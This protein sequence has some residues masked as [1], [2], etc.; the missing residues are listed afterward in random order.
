MPVLVQHRQSACPVRDDR[1]SDTREGAMSEDGGGFTVFTG[2]LIRLLAEGVPNA[3]QEFLDLDTIFNELHKSLRA[4]SR[5]LP[6]KR[7]RNSL[8]RLSLARNPAWKSIEKDASTD[9][10]LDV[11]IIYSNKHVAI[12]R[13]AVRDPAASDEDAS[14]A[15]PDSGKRESRIDSKPDLPRWPPVAEPGAKSFTLYS[16][17]TPVVE[18]SV[19]P[20]GESTES[21]RL[22]PPLDNQSA[23]HA[24]A[25]NAM[26]RSSTP[27]HRGDMSAT[28]QVI[29]DAVKVRRRLAWIVLTQNAQFS[30]VD[31]EVL[32]LAFRNE[33]AIKTYFSARIDKILDQVIIED[34]KLSWVV[35]ASALKGAGAN[36][37]AQVPRPEQGR[38]PGEWPLFRNDEGGVKKFG[39][40]A[41]EAG[42]RDPSVWPAVR[43][44]PPPENSRRVHELWPTVLE[45][46]RRRRRF[47][48]LLLSY[49]SLAGVEE[50]TIRLE[51][52]S[53]HARDAYLAIG[54]SRLIKEVAAEILRFNCEIDPVIAER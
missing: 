20:K 33:S 11:P 9:V 42:V 28:W 49:A 27:F 5:P 37:L 15:L 35:K 22:S 6:H 19:A 16:S 13:A 52:V 14:S 51:F 53:E 46:V 30:G 43:K 34:L 38:R 29:L 45:E 32:N 25:E 40:S 23:V 2:E 50:K 21:V 24:Q 17:V 7:V 1:A 48:W 4:K 47:A 18:R 44:P 39:N 3:A 41:N 10:M 31:G 36:P 8:G 12:G 26:L 54:A